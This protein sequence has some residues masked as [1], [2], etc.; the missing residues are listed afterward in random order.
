VVAWITAQL[1][2][3][4]EFLD[5]ETQLIVATVRQGLIATIDRKVEQ[6]EVEV[7]NS[8][9]RLSRF[10]VTFT[11]GFP[12]A[13]SDAERENR[14][15]RGYGACRLKMSLTGLQSSAQ[16]WVS[17][18]PFAVNG[19]NS[20]VNEIANLSHIN[21]DWRK[22]PTIEVAFGSQQ[23]RVVELPAG[24]DAKQGRSAEWTWTAKEVPRRPS[25]ASVVF[26]VL[27]GGTDEVMVSLSF[28]PINSTCCPTWYRVE[29][30][31]FQDT[32]YLQN[33]K[34]I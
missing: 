2:G 30:P 7:N 6:I 27:V 20:A 17:V 31:R 18:A 32:G 1:S 14:E 26:L 23:Y 13:F 15:T 16:V 5:G 21:D 11:E 34:L 3:S 24:L 10:K 25:V 29:S 12:G 22:T 9:V 8:T 33:L 28:S 4:E 19:L